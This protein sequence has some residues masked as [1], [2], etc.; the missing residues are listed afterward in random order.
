M[1]PRFL[2]IIPR[3]PSTRI[4]IGVIVYTDIF[5]NEVDTNIQMPD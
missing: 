1:I 2:L 4:S 3:W 5:Q